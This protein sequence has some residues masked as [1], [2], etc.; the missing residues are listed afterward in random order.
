M[1]VAIN[2]VLEERDSA[3]RGGPK[4]K[5]GYKEAANYLYGLDGDAPLSIVE[6]SKLIG[7]SRGRVWQIKKSINRLLRCRLPREYPELF[8][9]FE[10]SRR[11]AWWL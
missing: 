1:N 2:K 10:V 9:S 6:V 3:V 11:S 4:I 7:R 8:E 5:C